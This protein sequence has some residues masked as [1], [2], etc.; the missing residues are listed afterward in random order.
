MD[1]DMDGQHTSFGRSSLIFTTPTQSTAKMEI[2]ARPTLQSCSVHESQFLA[3]W[4]G[5]GLHLCPP[6]VPLLL[7]ASENFAQ[8][9]GVCQ[10]STRGIVIA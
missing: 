10:R 3:C 8:N 2:T 5:V 4:M 1:Y 6:R 7:R 9:L